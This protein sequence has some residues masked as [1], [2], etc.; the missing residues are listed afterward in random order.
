[1]NSER[2]CDRYHTG[3]TCILKLFLVILVIA[4]VILAWVPPVSRDAL[5]HHLAVPKLYI[6][7]GGMVEIPYIPFSYYPMNLDLLYILPLHFGND[8]LPKLIHYAFALLTAGLIHGY[9]KKRL[10][11]LYAWAGVFIF[12]TVPVI[13]KLSITVYVDLGLVFFITA[14]LVYLFKW[15]EDGLQFRHLAISA[16]FCGLGLGTKYNGLVALFILVLFIAYAFIHTDKGVNNK[17]KQV[18]AVGYAAAY[19]IIAALVFSPWMVRNVLWKGNP[20]YPLY[21]SVFN[22]S[23]VKTTSPADAELDAQIKERTGGWT[24]LAVRRILYNESWIQLALIPF[25]MFFVGQDNDPKYFD[26]KLNPFLLLLPIFAFFYTHHST[27]QTVRLE[28]RMLLLFSILFMLISF[29]RTSIRIRY[30]TPIIPALT[31]LSVLGLHNLMRYFNDRKLRPTRQIG[32]ASLTVVVLLMLGMNTAYIVNQ[33]G[34]VKPF[35]YISG[36]VDREAYILRHRPEYA[37][38]DYANRH[39]PQDARIMG[40][41]MGNRRYYCD[42]KLI[43]AEN[44]L[45]K[46]VI[47]AQSAE[48]IGRLFKRRGYTHLMLNFKLFKQWTNGLTDREKKILVEFLNK[49]LKLIYRKDGYGLFRLKHIAA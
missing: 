44:N 47:R 32:T 36:R 49:D 21:N 31:I 5:T 7:H 27:S 45:A 1:M 26:G 37:V 2:V 23:P 43:F 28:M 22:S 46:E 6:E 17:R 30:I 18:K 34:L 40:L 3:S 41:Y 8:I 25:R 35:D 29:L 33:F 42:R 11:T 20:I 48:H 16:V 24:H 14:A 15:M 9:L 39:L 12:L 10:D 38:F 13:L 4:T 19:F